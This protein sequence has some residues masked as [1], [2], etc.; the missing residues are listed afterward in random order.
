MNEKTLE[1]KL[2]DRVRAKNGLALKFISPSFT[3]VPDRI[4]LLPRGTIYFAEIKT[5]GKQPT[6]R[7]K[8]VHEILRGL[9]FYVAVIDSEKTLEDF[10]GVME[11]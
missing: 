8:I 3:G 10:Y 6:E 11:I 9:G 4:I 2:R 1:K 7:Q 5:T